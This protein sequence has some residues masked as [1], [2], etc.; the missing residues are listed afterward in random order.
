MSKIYYFSHSRAE[1]DSYCP[2]KRYLSSEWGGTGLEATQGGWDM[3][4]G[5][6]IHKYL[7]LQAMGAGFG[8]TDIRHEVQVEAIKY[9]GENMAKDYAA[10]AEGLVRGFVK[11]IWPRLMSEFEVVESEQL[12]SFIPE[13]P[14][15]FR[16]KQDILLRHKTE[17]YLVY[18]DYKTTSSDSPQWITSWTKHPQ[19][20]SS[21]YALERGQ[22]GLKVG[23]AIVLGLFKGWKDKKHNRLGSIFCK[24]WVNR[25]FPMSPAYSYTYK[26]GKGWEPFG[27][28]DEFDDLGGWV[29]NMPAEILAAQF[30]QTAP[31]FLRED[32]AETY[33]RQQLWREKEVKGALEG[34]EQAS[35]YGVNAD[36]INILDEHFPQDFH[37]CDPAYGFKCDMM[38]IC[39]IPFIE[40]D[41][42]GS[43]Q[44]IRR[45]PQFEEVVE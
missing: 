30:P 44:F 15:V 18:L 29:A 19:L 36:I 11:S 5:N 24:G 33:F 14:F 13:E 39:W 17:G 40:A 22:A 26:A 45:T 1:A 42:L 16:F 6:I 23:H 34:L 8:Y 10:L 3:L 28:F 21:M 37:K 35:E 31:I 7:N 32:V 12:K 20:H 41:P 27:T 25:E 38:P 2:R 4:F 9:F 43:K